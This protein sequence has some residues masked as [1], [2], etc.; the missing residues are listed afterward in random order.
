MNALD[1]VLEFFSNVLMRFAVRLPVSP[2]DFSS[3][4]S[5]IR[6]ILGYVNYFIP[7]YLFSQ[8]LTVWYAMVVSAI[9]I[10]LV[11]RWLIN[12]VSK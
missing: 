3:Y 1:Y 8:I 10:F 11:I 6:G 4:V 9:G 12:A 5:A 7:F 2:F